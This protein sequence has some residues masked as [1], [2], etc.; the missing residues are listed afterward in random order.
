MESLEEQVARVIA[1]WPPLTDTQ[2]DRIAALLRAGS[3][4]GEG[5][6]ADAA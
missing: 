5:G 6:D 3:R 4:V 2:L 1:N